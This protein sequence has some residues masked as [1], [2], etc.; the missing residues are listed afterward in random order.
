MYAIKM[1]IPVTFVFVQNIFY[2]CTEI[3]SFFNFIYIWNDDLLLVML[4]ICM[5]MS[6]FYKG[7]HFI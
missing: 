3:Y 1:R 5:Y 2:K 4:I 7:Q 6:Q